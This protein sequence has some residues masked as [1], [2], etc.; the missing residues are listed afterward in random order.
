VFVLGYKASS[1]INF[2]VAPAVYPTLDFAQMALK[3]KRFES[4]LQWAILTVRPVDSDYAAEQTPSQDSPSLPEA[5]AVP[6][7]VMAS[8]AALLG[9]CDSG[10]MGPHP[11]FSSCENWHED[12]GAL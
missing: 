5:G 8:E 3:V 4:S 11:H 7:V 1:D 2:S 12:G 6:V 10:H 9:V